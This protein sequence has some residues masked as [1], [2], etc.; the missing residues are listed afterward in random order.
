MSKFRAWLLSQSTLALF[1]QSGVPGQGWQDIPATWFN[2]KHSNPAGAGP[3]LS[4]LTAIPDFADSGARGA[5]LEQWYDAVLQAGYTPSITMTSAEAVGLPRSMPKLEVWCLSY[6]AEDASVR[7][8]YEHLSRTE[9]QICTQWSAFRYGGELAY[10]GPEPKDSM[11]RRCYA[12]ALKDWF[13]M[14]ETKATMAAVCADMSTWDSHCVSDLP[15]DAFVW[16]PAGTLLGPGECDA[17]VPLK[18]FPFCGLCLDERGEPG[19]VGLLPDSW[20]WDGGRIRARLREF[21]SAAGA[22]AA[23]YMEL[24]H[25]LGKGLLI[26]PPKRENPHLALHAADDLLYFPLTLKGGNDSVAISV[27]VLNNRLHIAPSF[28]EGDAASYV[29]YFIDL[30]KCAVA[31]WPCAEKIGRRLSRRSEMLDID[32][33]LNWPALTP[34]LDLHIKYKEA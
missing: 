34:A 4:R 13:A 28:H 29:L 21:C 2:W 8:A 12:K 6:D 1:G 11:Q 26:V 10:A 19:T 5:W 32:S 15:L 31:P 27:D 22:A 16:P 23:L 7:Q 18:N 33:S 20:E 17:F 30:E 14:P 3:A 25:K 9:L 24:M